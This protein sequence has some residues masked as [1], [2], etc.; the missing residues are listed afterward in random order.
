M[1]TLGRVSDSKRAERVGTRSPTEAASAGDAVK[2][3]RFAAEVR[4]P[5][6]AS[7]SACY[8]AEAE[9]GGLAR[10]PGIDSEAAPREVH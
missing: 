8:R 9:I 4:G 5:A 6:A 3:S 10:A 1:A 7:D 2:A